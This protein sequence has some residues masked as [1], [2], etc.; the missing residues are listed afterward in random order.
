MS[1]GGFSENVVQMELHQ[2]RQVAGSEYSSWAD[3][4]KNDEG[5][6]RSLGKYPRLAENMQR[7]SEYDGMIGHQMTVQIQNAC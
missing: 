3:V 1:G 2:I 6:F 4:L 5:P 7:S